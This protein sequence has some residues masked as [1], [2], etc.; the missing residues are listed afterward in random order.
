MRSWP[1]VP[2]SGAITQPSIS[3]G[4]VLGAHHRDIEDRC[5]AL[6]SRTGRTRDDAR[7][8]TRRW[9]QLE[10]AL[11]EHMAAE[12]RMVFLAY[13]RADARDARHLLDEHST[14]RERALEI[15]IAIHL[16]TLRSEHV[17]RFVD[18]LR[19][20]AR[21]EDASLYRW[22]QRNLDHKERHALHALIG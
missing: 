10:H 4:D 3:V 20:H 14:L 5:L 15:G 8:L 9:E 6:L 2:A 22:A 1:S 18:Q 11:F 17:Q 12:E 7:G 16:G 13:Q 21:H 19:A